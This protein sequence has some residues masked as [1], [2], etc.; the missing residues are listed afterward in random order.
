MK[1]TLSLIIIGLFVAGAIN[2]TLSF[3]G[4][5]VRTASDA[6]LQN[7]IRALGIMSG[8][9]DGD[10]KLNF[11]ISRAEFAQMMVNASVYKGS[12]TGA[13]ATSVFNDVKFDHWAAGAI[14]TATNAGWFRGYLDGS[15]RPSGLITYEQGAAALLKQLGYYEADLDAPYPTG[16]VA[17]FEALGL[18]DGISLKL[19]DLITRRDAMKIFINLLETRGKDGR[20]YGETLGYRLIG[21]RL[22][23]NYLV[24][25]GLSGPFVVQDSFTL[26]FAGNATAI[27]RDGFATELEA[28]QR[29]DVV[30]VHEK[31]RTV[32]AFSEK[33]TGLVTQI[34]PSRSAPSSVIVGGSSYTLGTPEAIYQFSG[35]GDFNAGDQVTLLLGK[36]GA[37]AAAVS[38]RSSIEPLYGVVKEVRVVNFVDLYGSTRAERVLEVIGTDGMLHQFSVN[39]TNYQTGELVSVL[40]GDSGVVITKIASKSLTGIFDLTAARFAGLSISSSIEIVEVS[41]EGKHQKLFATQLDGVSLRSVDIRYYV[42]DA[43]GA[44]TKLVLSHVTGDLNTYALITEVS[45]ETLIIPSG[46]VGVPDT[47]RTTGTYQ[48]LSNGVPSVLVKDT[49]LSLSIGGA[50]LLYDDRSVS[51]LTN[52]SGVSIQSL[53]SQIALSSQKQYLLSDQIES[54]ERIDGNYH[55]VSPIAVSDV[56]K[57]TLTGYYDSGF[58]AGGKIRVILAVRK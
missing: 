21:G 13:I 33:R 58:S 46:I 22:D 43:A 39:K 31:L 30:Y 50:R 55:R 2:T 11:R 57:Y 7:T 4:E 35:S 18:S 45:E 41:S 29:L 25:S 14:R 49:F 37:V 6:Q 52:L 53:D 48:Y 12:G 3:A 36:D 20:F 24:D 40:S 47:V 51:G 27:L 44:I 17:K 10:L 23:Y 5:T 38:Q 1:K 26:P 54:Y 16:H 28:L 42:Q 9:K 56:S 8:Y 15:F 34:L 19:G 32:W